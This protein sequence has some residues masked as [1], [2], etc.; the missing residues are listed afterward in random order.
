MKIFFIL[1]LISL[2]IVEPAISQEK[3]D[4][5]ISV[6]KPELTIKKYNNEYILSNDSLKKQLI[7]PFAGDTKAQQCVNSTVKEDKSTKREISVIETS[8]KFEYLI[9]N[10]KMQFSG[11]NSVNIKDNKLTITLN[12]FQG[13]DSYE[14]LTNKYITK[15]IYKGDLITG[16]AVNIFTLGIPLIIAPKRSIDLSLGCTDE[17]ISKREIDRTRSEIKHE[18]TFWKKAVFSESFKIIG[19]NFIFD[20]DDI[21]DKNHI[22]QRGQIVT[23]D[24]NKK[25]KFDSNYEASNLF[26]TCKSCNL[27]SAEHQLILGAANIESKVVA[28]LKYIK[29]DLEIAEEL[30]QKKIKLAFEEKKATKEGAFCAGKHNSRYIDDEFTKC[31]EDE[32]VKTASQQKYLDAIATK[33]GGSCS[34]RFK[35]DNKHFWTCY[36]KNVAEFNAKKVAEESRLIALKKFSDA[37]ATNEGE[38]CKKKFKID[39]NE[40]WR[41]FEKTV[42]EVM[43]KQKQQEATEFEEKL[44]KTE[45]ANLLKRDDIARQC[46]EIGFEISSPPYKECYLKLKLHTE[47][48]AEWRKLQTALQNQTSQQSPTQSG[49]VNY[50]GSAAS[51][52][53]SG[54]VEALLGIAQRGLDMASGQNR[55]A[56]TFL[57][58]PPPPM[59]IITPRG[60]SYNCSMMGAT[61][62]CR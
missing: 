17:I 41:C 49:N 6:K 42:A 34:V 46:V 23:V 11:I 47:Q 10:P 7:N 1:I 12:Q 9:E 35:V 29:S 56:P 33:E 55:P 4:V 16:V 22:I 37:V 31:Y 38:Q 48:I 59:Q 3:I 19:P 58:M 60:N 15:I 61:M 45:L 30:R 54:Q 5:S 40:F 39:G 20:S 43:L 44:K 21:E 26:I 8:E 14:S 57:P 25:L 18:T 2:F 13:Y 32:L 50:G 62:R 51:N 52:V 27:I 28:N 24:L 53:N 36:D